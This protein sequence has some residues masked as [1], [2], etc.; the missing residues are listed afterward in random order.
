[1]SQDSPYLSGDAAARQAWTFRNS[2]VFIPVTL[3]AVAIANASFE[4]SPIDD[5][6]D[7]LA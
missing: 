3:L 4:L 5:T 6:G 1:M 2:V 7:R